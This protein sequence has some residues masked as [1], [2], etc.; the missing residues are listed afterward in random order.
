MSGWNENPEFTETESY[1]NKPLFGVTGGQRARAGDSY[2]LR[3]DSDGETVETEQGSR[4]AAD[5]ELV[6]AS[7]VPVTSDG[8][9]IEDGTP[10]RLMTGSSRFLGEL[11]EH[12]PVGGKTLTVTVEGT[13]Y[14]AQYSIA[15]A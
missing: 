6:E 4:V 9:E 8:D 13:G 1:D 3:F 12:A 2:T 10:V 5:A 14:D 11:A 15:E 7:F